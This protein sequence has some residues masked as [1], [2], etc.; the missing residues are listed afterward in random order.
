MAVILILQINTFSLSGR[1]RPIFSSYR[2]LTLLAGWAERQRVA[3]AFS[4]GKQ[5]SLSEFRPGI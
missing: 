2:T 4:D 5:P 3:Q 1:K